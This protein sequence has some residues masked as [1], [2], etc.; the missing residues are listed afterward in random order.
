[1]SWLRYARILLPSIMQALIV[2]ESLFTDKRIRRRFMKTWAARVN[3]LALA[4]LEE[5]EDQIDDIEEDTSAIENVD[6]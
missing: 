6:E 2:S 4:T 5:L 1:M 3:E